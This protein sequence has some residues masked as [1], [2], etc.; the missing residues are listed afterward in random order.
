MESKR[1]NTAI[2]HRHLSFLL[3]TAMLQLCAA[4]HAKDAAAILDLD[5][6]VACHAAIEKVR[7]DNRI[8]PKGN[9]GQKPTFSEMVSPD[10]LQEQALDSVRMT[11][12]AKQIY[13]ISI[14]SRLLQQELNRMV[15]HSRDPDGLAKLFAAVKNDP[16]KVVECLVRPLVVKR[17][18]KNAFSADD[19][20][21]GPQ[22][23]QLHSK[24]RSQSAKRVALTTSGKTHAYTALH[25][26]LPSSDSPQ[27]TQVS[28][29]TWAQLKA[30]WQNH[31]KNHHNAASLE[32][33]QESPTSFFVRNVQRVDAKRFRVTTTY[34]PKTRFSTW[35][36]ANKQSIPT[37]L[38]KTKKHPYELPAFDAKAD[39]IGAQNLHEE[40]IVDYQ[41]LSPRSGHKA[42]WTGSEMIVWGGYSHNDGA[43][44][45]PATDSWRPI[46]SAGAPTSRSRFTAIWTGTEMI[47]WG[48]YESGLPLGTGARYNYFTDTWRPLPTVNAP[49]PRYYHT[50]VWAGDRMIIW[51]G[52][53]GNNP[54]GGGAVYRPQHNNWFS[55]TGTNAPDARDRHTAVWTGSE[56][57]VWGG[58]SDNYTNTGGR[59]NP[60]NDT[61]TD[62]SRE[63]VAQWRINHSAVWT[64]DKMLVWGGRSFRNVLGNGGMYTP[65]TN[66]WEPITELNAVRE[67]ELHSAVWTGDRM[68]I[69]GGRYYTPRESYHGGLFNPETNSWSPIPNML[70]GRYNDDFTE[71]ST[72][73]TGSEMIVFGEH[74]VGKYL[75]R[76][77]VAANTWTYPRNSTRPYIFDSPASVW[78]GNEILFWGGNFEFSHPF[79]YE[80]ATNMWSLRSD[81][82]AP[83]PTKG[84]GGVWTGTEMIVWGGEY[85]STLAQGRYSPT[86][87]SWSPMTSEGHPY[88][89]LNPRMIWI[90]THMFLWCQSDSM[91]LYNPTSDSWSTT[92]P[93]IPG[94]G[95]LDDLCQASLTWTGSE[96]LVWGGEFNEEPPEYPN[97]VFRYQPETDLWSYSNPDNAPEGR[98]LPKS[99]WTG[100]KL[101]VWGGVTEHPD[102]LGT[103]GIYD[104]ETNQWASTSTVNAPEPRAS[105]AASW[106]G[107]EM[108]IWGGYGT[109]G[110][111]NTGHRFDPNTNTWTP[112]TTRGALSARTVANSYWMNDGMMVIG[113]DYYVDVFGIYKP[114]ELIYQGNFEAP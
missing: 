48:G 93:D 103:G 97:F 101:V 41:G 91:S 38:P 83:N 21:H 98:R 13:D 51:G 27:E 72:V 11:Q 5:A 73:W 2:F 104:P 61:W 54:L 44:Y 56:M 35:W 89:R 79:H 80:P 95:N 63:N 46:S 55:I 70:Q 12:A 75:G 53:N 88:A 86:L 34:W 23:Q 49:S 67:R 14:T 10:W 19:S 31:S 59:Y 6:R 9:P 106:S 85:H 43:I 96:L 78:T 16:N 8:W 111:L 81:L 22:K 28:A 36:T 15:A 62:T 68:L 82:N 50:A 66:S 99:V 42:V 90:G 100:S 105:F 30:S 112:M 39:G 57:I 92:T 29:N 94:V 52:H 25:P 4:A 74:E 109:D 58:Y 60:S 32:A 114:G 102:Y 77:D 113:R 37:Q 69:W 110:R 3:I 40:W 18:L 65:A 107:I 24:L 17:L 1:P 45:S 87:D 20:V 76:F 71:H 33:L 47:I 84:V 108:I 64:G 26:D 7:W